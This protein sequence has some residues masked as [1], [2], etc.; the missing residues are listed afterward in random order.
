M[1]VYSPCCG[2]VPH[3]VPLSDRPQPEVIRAILC[4]ARLLTTIR[5]DQGQFMLGIA[6][7]TAFRGDPGHAAGGRSTFAA[8]VHHCG[9]LTLPSA[10]RTPVWPFIAW[11]AWSKPQTWDSSERVATAAG[12]PNWSPGPRMDRT[13]DV[14][15]PISH[16]SSPL[17]PT[18]L[19]TLLAVSQ[20]AL[21]SNSAQLCVPRN[22]ESD[23]TSSY[24]TPRL[25]HLEF[26]SR[27][28]THRPVVQAGELEGGAAELVLA[29][30][31]SRDSP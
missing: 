9:A 30:S 4:C 20:S 2:V 16:P 19:L 7:C 28:R 14:I 5:G 18:R 31:C 26:E 1:S 23:Y 25:M 24:K 15:T 3:G 8:A 17:R 13:G 10:S 12:V 27:V 29:Y 11:G 21:R 22:S 6:R